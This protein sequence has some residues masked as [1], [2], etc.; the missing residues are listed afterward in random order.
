MGFDLSLSFKSPA[1]A[2]AERMQDNATQKFIKDNN[3]DLSIDNPNSKED[4]LKT[5]NFIKA[6]SNAHPRP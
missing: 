1:D 2:L 4:I 5:Y 3:L 6:Y